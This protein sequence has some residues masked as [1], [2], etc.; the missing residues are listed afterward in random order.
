MHWL[1]RP[2]P[3]K[4]W[5]IEIHKGKRSRPA[6][7]MRVFERLLLA[8]NTRDL[9][10]Q[11]S[12]N[13]TWSIGPH[14]Q[15]EDQEC[16]SPMSLLSNSNCLRE[17]FWTFWTLSHHSYCTVVLLAKG[18]LVND[19]C[20]SD[21][22]GLGVSARTSRTD[23]GTLSLTI[24]MCSAFFPLLSLSLGSLFLRPCAKIKTV[25]RTDTP[26]TLSN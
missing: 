1:S 12:T 26:F 13:H 3:L 15:W 17:T 6:V 4:M 9:D 5:V 21:H 10:V 22:S 25:H 19:E 2:N 18:P 7:N 14:T 23:E 20:N 11:V 24:L 16:I 8:G